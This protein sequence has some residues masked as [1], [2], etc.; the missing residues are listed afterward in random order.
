MNKILSVCVVN[1]NTKY[2]LGQCLSSLLE[3]S[4]GLDVEIVVVDNHSW[5]ESVNMIKRDFPEVKLIANKRNTGYAHA[6][7]QA[8]KL[9]RGD[10]ILVLN[11]DTVVLPATL[12][13]T[14]QFMDHQK[15]AGIVGCRVLNPDKT[16]QKS[17]R[18]FPS[19]LNYIYENFYF[20]RLFSQSRWFGRPFMSYFKYDEIREVDVVLG[21][22]MMTR[23]E[24]VDQIGGMDE[25][26]FM[27]SEETDYCYRAKQNGWKVY[28]YPDAEIIHFGGQSTQDAS[29]RMF[30]ELHKSHLR[31][32][33]K[34]QGKGYMFVVKI[35]L[36]CGIV[37]RVFISFV[38]CILDFLGK[39]NPDESKRR[40]T[41]YWRAL[42]WHF[43]IPLKV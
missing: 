12:L 2:L 19:I 13:Q 24:L 7:N 3:H 31:Y 30:I 39:K 20:D 21:A 22:F 23:R 11:S 1:Y 28:F 40:L 15:D 43:G 9:S 10:F 4:E 17:C 34:Y 35:I 36:M 29:V 6:V 5:D 8:I 38:V 25:Q 37:V 14:L 18:S 33:S 26:F 16:L 42:K 27:Y 41:R 32:A